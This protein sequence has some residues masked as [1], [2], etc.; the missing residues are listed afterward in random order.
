MKELN[1]KQK[2]LAQIKKQ[3][4][5]E[6]GIDN[7]RKYKTMYPNELD[8]ALYTKGEAL[9]YTKDIRD[10]YSDYKF[11]TTQ[12]VF[13]HYKSDIRKVVDSLC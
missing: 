5:Q 9:F 10:L 6:V 4:T 11:S 7:L 3:L 1:R 2:V 12:K 8:Y 13:E